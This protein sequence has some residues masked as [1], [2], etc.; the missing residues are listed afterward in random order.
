VAFAPVRVLGLGNV[1]MGDDALGPW[2]IEEL[3]AQ[4][5]FPEGVSVVDVGTPGLDLTPYLAEADTILLVDTVKSDAPPGTLLVYT[6]DQLLRHPPPPRLS[7]HDPGLTEALF[8]LDF[9]GAAPKDI[10]LIGVVPGRVEKGVGLTP[11]VREGVAAA[12]AEVVA[13]LKA[14]GF[15][16]RPRDAGPSAPWWERP[17]G[18]RIVA[19]R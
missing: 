16:P 8:S 17:A 3:L 10:V 2:V 19:L 9:S 12:A 11:A 5:E 6:R 14:L 18:E 13:A 4:W 15:E 7:P 1:L